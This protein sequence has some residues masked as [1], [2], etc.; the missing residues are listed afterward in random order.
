[1]LKDNEDNSLQTNQDEQ[2]VQSNLDEEVQGEISQIKS[3]NK[4]RILLITLIVVIN[5]L[6]LYF[7]LSKFFLN[8]STD[9]QG[10]SLSS[11]PSLVNTLNTEHTDNVIVPILPEIPKIIT[12]DLPP[13][14]P[15]V[16]TQPSNPA[17]NNSDSTQAN[18]APSLPPPAASVDT[19]PPAI[20]TPPISALPTVDLSAAAEEK[21]QR[22]L[23]KRTSTN[24][25]VISKPMPQP[26]QYELEQSANFTD[27]GNLKHL[28]SRGTTIDAVII[29]A[30][31]SNLSPQGEIMAMITND[32]YAS[33]GK[34]VLI[35]R[36]SKVFGSINILPGGAYGRL[37][38]TWEQI[39]I[40]GSRYKLN[41][42]SAPA[43][44]NL[45]LPGTKG[46][47]D[48]RIIARIVHS[49]MI[50]ATNIGTAYLLDKAN[51]LTASG[52]TNTGSS[53]IASALMKNAL[54]I[55]TQNKGDKQKIIEICATS[56]NSIITDKQSELFNIINNKCT[57]VQ[58]NASS[59]DQQRLDSLMDTIV[60]TTMNYTSTQNSNMRTATKNALS[61]IINSLKDIVPEQEL[62][63]V[64]TLKQ[65]HH[66][67]IYVNKDYLFP[68]KVLNKAKLN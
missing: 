27:A 5:I 28:L 20:S 49:T 43:I 63:R 2:Q 54:A 40:A 50:S 57:E 12:P 55:R 62:N 32:V 18:N 34:L 64:I 30:V 38:V 41:L 42:S 26:T 15:P 3:S 7:L 66:I 36:G 52:F 33:Q 67:K 46:T 13:I 53:S 23:A 47:V 56:T 61:N 25:I 4:L 37:I 11:S 16:I 14:N 22:L 68:T 44:D 59:N 48:N 9:T 8:E 24:T 6:A 21:Q 17:I 19:S 60:N 31:N 65:G 51:I 1:M 58:A 29:N 45:G 10:N 39:Q 35:P